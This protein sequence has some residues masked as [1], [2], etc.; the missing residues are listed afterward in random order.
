MLRNRLRSEIMV[1]ILSALGLPEAKA[2][3]K[4]GFLAKALGEGG[5]VVWKGCGCFSARSAKNT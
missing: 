2:R 5:L 4:R 1:Y 3:R